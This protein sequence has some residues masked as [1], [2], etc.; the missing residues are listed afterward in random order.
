MYGNAAARAYK[1][2]DL[3]SAPKTQIVERLFDRFAR[4]VEDV[5]GALAKKDIETKAKA[6]NHASAIVLQLKIALDHKVAPDMCSNLESLY[7]YVVA[8]LAECNAK[9]STRPLDN[10]AR[11]MAGLGDAFKKAHAK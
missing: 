3:E 7:N 8:Q 11:V 9:L 2:V 1:R 4:D 5:R 10:A 6:I